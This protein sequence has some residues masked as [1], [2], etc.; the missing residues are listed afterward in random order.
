MSREM[1]PVTSIVDPPFPRNFGRLVLGCMDSYDSEQRAFFC[2]F[3]NL[4]DLQTFAPLQSPNFRKMFGDFLLK[5]LD[6]RGA[7]VIL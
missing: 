2:I 4:Q 1:P 6:L 5:F 7:K 3:Q